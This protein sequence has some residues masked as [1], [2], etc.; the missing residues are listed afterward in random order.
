MNFLP[1]GRQTIEDDDIRAVQ[2]ALRDDFLTTGPKVVEFERRLAQCTEFAHAV[3]VSNGTAAL[4][5]ACAAANIGPEDEVIVPAITFVASANC[6]RYLGAKVV[7]AD[8]DPNTGLATPATIERCISDRTKAIICVDLAGMPAEIDALAAL[9]ES[10][11]ALLIEDAA[12]SLGAAFKQQ[13][14]GQAGAHLATLSFHPVKHITT[15]EGGAVLTND[16]ALAEKL[17]RFREHGIVRDADN[18]QNESPGPWYYEQQELGFNYRLP[19]L[20]CALGLSQL[21]KLER[22][23]QRRNEIAELYAQLL[24]D[25]PHVKPLTRPGYL[26]RSAHHLYVV[27]V[28]FDAAGRSRREVMQ[29]LRDAGVGSQVHY[30]PVPSQPYYAG[31]GEDVA[32]YPGACEYYSKALSIP[33]YPALTDSDVAR[34]VKAL[35]AAV[36]G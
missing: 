22:F 33:M 4:H 31:L 24:V 19:D 10:N 32:R 14:L 35:E 5:C 2:A 21:S 25:L 18:W 28:D 13:A 17:R 36:C 20:A 30:I 7:F 29:R 3:A 26:A 23:V 6:A 8:V 12:H 27:Q 15:G 1:Y 9:A 16:A 11:T 34:V